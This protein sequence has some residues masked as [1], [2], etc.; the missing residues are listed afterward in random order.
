MILLVIDHYYLLTKI[1]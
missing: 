1:C